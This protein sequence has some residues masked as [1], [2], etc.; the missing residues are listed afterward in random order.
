MRKG[1]PS[2]ASELLT[3]PKLL[4]KLRRDPTY[5]VLSLRS[6]RPSVTLCS[7]IKKL[8]AQAHKQRGH[9]QTGL[10]LAFKGTSHE[11]AKNPYIEDR[12]L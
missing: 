1:A 7:T 5:S 2:L 9:H 11:Q 6:E 8:V 4:W 10:S 3:S 12:G